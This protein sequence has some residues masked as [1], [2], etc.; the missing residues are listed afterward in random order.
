MEGV[1][2]VVTM[3]AYDF[4]PKNWAYCNGQLLAI[5]Q[6]QAL[7]SILGTTY[8]GNG[9]QTFALPDL[10][11]R[12][13]AGVGQGPGLSNYTLG[14]VGGT[15]TVTLNVNNLPPHVHTGAVT[16]TPKGGSIGDN[17]DPSGFSP[18]PIPTGYIAT[19]TPGNNMAAPVYSNT[20]IGITGSSQPVPILTPYLTVNYV[21]CLYGIFPS[22]N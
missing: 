7:F 10:R 16:I 9:V 15:E 21:V 20:V 19:G 5:A 6:N 22:R 17:G 3:V 4:A 2:G 14:E 1:I 11:G 13:P 12:I 18:G 8:G